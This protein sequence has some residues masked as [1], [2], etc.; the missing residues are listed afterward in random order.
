MAPPREN[1]EDFPECLV[2]APLQDLKLPDVPMPMAES[3][4]GDGMRRRRFRFSTRPA[5]EMSAT[6][7]IMAQERRRLVM[8]TRCVVGT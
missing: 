8:T 4:A 3:S 7:A 2:S 6:D 1:R 5:R